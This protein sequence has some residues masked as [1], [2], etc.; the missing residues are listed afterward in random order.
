[1]INKILKFCGYVE[2]WH[3]A[4]VSLIQGR[5]ASYGDGCYPIE[6]GMSIRTIPALKEFLAEEMSKAV[7]ENVSSKQITII[8]MTRIKR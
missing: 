1:M 2:T 3:V 7:G 5:A 8:S 6:G 4:W